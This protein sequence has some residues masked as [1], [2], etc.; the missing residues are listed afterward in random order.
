M[1]TE[2]YNGINS[3]MVGV[4]KLI[5]KY[6]IRREV[7]N[8]VCWEL[9]EPLFVKIKN[10]QSRWINI[11]ERK[12]NPYLPY[13]ESLWL[14]SGRNDL[15]M[16]EAY[17]KKL[18]DF[19]DDGLFLRGGY[20]PRFRY[21]NG[22]PEDYNIGNDR[23]QDSFEID[24]FQFV[25]ESF[26]RDPFTRQAIIQ[27]GDPIKDC[28][29]TS[30]RLKE[31]KDFPCSRSLQFSRQ[32]ET[33]KLDLTVY[34]RSNDLLWGATG[35]NIFN[36]T[37]IQEYIANILGLDVG[38]YYH[39]AN[40]IHYYESFKSRIEALARMKNVEDRIYSYVLKCNSL[41]HFDKKISDL[42]EWESELRNTPGIELIYFED[43]FFSDWAKVIY[44]FHEKSKLKFE[45][46]ILN[47]LFKN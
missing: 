17:V 21:Y 7:R 35:V 16:L 29:L 36:F 39:F 31:T 23:L 27:V 38:N 15:A 2:E 42:L 37:F 4:S 28:F 19:S 40:N 41:I 25:I 8:S 22:N 11:S 46:P 26:K 5:L 47:D 6:G 43:P 13:I 3:F 33:N 20:G 1:F 24:Q 9:P 10:P 18:R 45:N 34:M 14:A 30:G 44:R 32:P 12:W